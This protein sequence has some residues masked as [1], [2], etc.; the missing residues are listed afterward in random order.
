MKRYEASATSKNFQFDFEFAVTI[1][2]E[3]AHVFGFLHYGFGDVPEPFHTLGDPFNEMGDSWEHSVFG[4]VAAFHFDL[5]KDLAMTLGYPFGRQLTTP[6]WH[7]RIIPISLK[8]IA[9]WFQKSTWKAIRKHGRAI[10]KS[11]SCIFA[12]EDISRPINLYRHVA[13]GTL[14]FTPARC[15]DRT[16]A[17]EATGGNEQPE[18]SGASDTAKSSS[19]STLTKGCTHTWECFC[20][21]E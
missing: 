6:G 18:G 1:V 10:I 5:E 13:F 16:S 14:A 11:P 20:S 9:Q 3:P 19:C 2:H 7:K 12:F 15:K 4:C 21:S 8:W 17:F